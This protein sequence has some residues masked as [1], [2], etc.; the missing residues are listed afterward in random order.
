MAAGDWIVT[1]EASCGSGVDV[2]SE[3]LDAFAVALADHFGA[4]SADDGP[5]RYSATIVVPAAVPQPEVVDTALSLFDAA[6]SEAALPPAVE[7]CARYTTEGEH[8]RWL[9]EGVGWLRSAAPAGVH[10]GRTHSRRILRH[11]CVRT[12]RRMPSDIRAVH[13]DA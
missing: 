9:T 7:A 8:D 2:S 13:C 11:D 12:H 4:V 1:V 10:L 6:A 3:M 5:R